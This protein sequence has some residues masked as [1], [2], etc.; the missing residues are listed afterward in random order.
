MPDIVVNGRVDQAWG[1]AGISAAIHEASGAYYLAPNS[2][3]N[4]HPA[5]KIGW[6]VSAGASFNLPGGDTFGVN[7]CYAEGATGFCTNMTAPT[8]TVIMALKTDIGQA[9]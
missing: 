7:A 9:R 8:H 4:G 6:A 1:F 2:V 3:N 5:D